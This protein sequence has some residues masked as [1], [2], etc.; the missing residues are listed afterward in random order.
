MFASCHLYGKLSNMTILAPKILGFWIRYM[1][2]SLHWSQEA[3]AELSGLNVR[4]IQ[5]IEAGEPINI[6]TRR[7]LARGL[8]YEDRDVFDDPVFIKQLT[9]IVGTA[10]SSAQLAQKEMLE[11]LFPDNMRMKAERVINGDVLER[12]IGRANAT[13]FHADEDIPQRAKQRV[14]SLF[15]YMGDMAKLYNQISFSERLVIHNELEIILK[16][17][18]SLGVAVYSAFRTA[19]TAG[20]NGQ[21][22]APLSIT[23][24]YLTV[25][26]TE[27][28]IKEMVVPRRIS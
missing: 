9:S 22:Q 12:M 11:G 4:T 13:A 19:K 2:D 14:A 6:T 24:G 25:V 8:G 23:V 10:S 7:A 28:A 5:R 26:P 18:K 21:S 15:D 3:L 20:E 17:L 16:E 1:R 27:K